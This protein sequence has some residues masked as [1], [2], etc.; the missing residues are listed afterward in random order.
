M[1]V[2]H[3]RAF[4][5]NV[6]NDMAEIDRVY[7]DG[8]FR[9]RGSYSHFLEKEEFLL[10]QSSRQDSLS[11]IVRREVEWLRRG[12]QARTRKSKARIDQAGRLMEELSDVVA[13]SRAWRRSI[14]RPPAAAPAPRGRRKHHQ[15]DGRPHAL[16]ELS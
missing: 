12:A 13:P 7:P 5:D 9:V 3:D 16:S 6:V 4:L 2:S 14:S 15:R 11:N 8:L 10:A 1:V